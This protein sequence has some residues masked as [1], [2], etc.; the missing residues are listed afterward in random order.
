MLAG[1]VIKEFG[2]VNAEATK[3]AFIT[4]YDKLGD[5]EV[6]RKKINCLC[7]DGAAVNMGRKHGA[8]IQLSDYCDVSRPYI[9]VG[10]YVRLR[11]QYFFYKYYKCLKRKIRTPQLTFIKTKQPKIHK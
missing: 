5:M 4:V 9:I 10:L 7:A 6:L 3:E 8:L 2:G 1:Q 11:R